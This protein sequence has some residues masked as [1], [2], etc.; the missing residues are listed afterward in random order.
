MRSRLQNHLHIPAET[1]RAPVGD[2]L[3]GDAV[4]SLEGLKQLLG[5]SNPKPQAHENGS[6]TVWR[7]ADLHAEWPITEPDTF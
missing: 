6:H 4:L 7:H 5:N 3:L 1:S 2:S